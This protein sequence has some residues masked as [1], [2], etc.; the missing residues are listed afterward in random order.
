MKRH[1]LTGSLL[2]LSVALTA[3]NDS[4][5]D[6]NFESKPAIPVNNIANPV[7][8][9][10]VAY[11]ETDL[12]AVADESVVMTYKMLGINNNETQATALLF[13]PKGT[14]PAKGWP[15]VAWA[16]GTTGVADQCAPSKNQ[17]NNDITNMITGLLKAGYIVVA[18]DYEGLGEPS[19]T[20]LHPF[21]NLK[22]E[23]YS[24]T[25]AVVAAKD[26]LGS[27]ASNQWMAVGHSQGGQ[28]ALGAAQYAVRASQMT[29]KGTVAL[30][31]A[32]NF[33]LILAGGEAQAGQETN[34]NKKI[35]TLAS[36]DTFTALIAAGLRNPNP[37]LQYSQVFKT[38]TDEIAKNAETDCYDVLGN[39]F[40]MAM[41][42]YAQTNGNLEG[43]SRTQANFM[44]IPVVKNFLDKDS[45]PLQVKVSTPVIIYQGEADP[46]VP[47]AATDV[48]VSLANQKQTSVQYITDGS[49]D[50][51]SVYA[52]N[53]ANIISD[54]KSLMPIQ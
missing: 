34:L 50:H 39:K 17:L 40:G 52:L 31:P 4:D 1:V 16:H 23:A 48:L 24:I 38:P 37:N 36:L 19:G 30:A 33:S 15:I 28:A 42:A 7:V 9:T 6:G 14:R 32:S 10:P 47:K 46:T 54:V 2:A 44:S 35:E 49:W 45:Q 20:E 43:Y 11:T 25:D 53:I 26:Y 3:C 21:L 8:A 5:D 18:P 29:Y 22:S 41:G 13:T 27:D 51:G 12:T